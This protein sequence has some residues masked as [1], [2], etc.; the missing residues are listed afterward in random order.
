VMQLGT[1]STGTGVVTA[2]RVSEMVFTS[3]ATL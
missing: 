3:P 2:G 1:V